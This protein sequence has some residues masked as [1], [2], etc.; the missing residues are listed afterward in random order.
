MLLDLGVSSLQLERAHRGFAFMRDGPL[1]MRMDASEDAPTAAD[2]LAFASR[3]ELISLLRRFGEEPHAVRIVNAIER[4]RGDGNMP[5]TT[6]QL[7]D[8]IASAVPPPGCG[9]GRSRY[10]NSYERKKIKRSGGGGA[11]GSRG[12]H[13]AARTFQAL[14]ICVND[15]LS[16]IKAAIVAAGRLL[17]PGGRLAVLT[18]HALEADTVRGCMQGGADGG[19]C[20]AVAIEPAGPVLRPDVSEVTANPRSRS[21]AL[22]RAI[23]AQ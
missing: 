20:T 16:E 22:H 18:F 8:L 5:R 15:E 6:R 3:R 4:A 2:L 11:P 14:R 9:G 23:R 13:P 17:R 10:Y 19:D 7:A 12:R 1:D 21:A